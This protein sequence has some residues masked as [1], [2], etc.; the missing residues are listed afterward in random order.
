MKKALGI[1]LLISLF[2]TAMTSLSFAEVDTVTSA[3]TEPAPAP[4]PKAPAPAVKPA[5][6]ATKV[7]NGTTYTVVKGDVF[8][9]IAKKH[10]LTIDQLAK[11]NPQVKNINKIYVG[12]KLNVKDYDDTII[13]FY[14]GK[15]A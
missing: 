1:V 11:L 7:T 6:N 14:Y 13:T 10:N 3:T 2:F 4:A 12:Q 9:K 5:A 8:W 15:D